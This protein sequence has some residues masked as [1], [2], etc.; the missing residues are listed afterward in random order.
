MKKLAY[1]YIKRS[2][3]PFCLM[4]DE[5]DAN[6]RIALYAVSDLRSDVKVKYTVA[7]LTSGEKYESVC[8][9]IS[10]KS[11]PVWYKP[12]ESGEKHFYLIDW[13]YEYEGVTITGRNHYI[14]S[15]IDLDFNEYIGYMKQCGFYDEFEGF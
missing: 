4:F 5:P 12:I 13:S 2:Q 7:D 11:I 6:G 10:D 9:G 8:T 15:I 1:H 3:Q 14:T